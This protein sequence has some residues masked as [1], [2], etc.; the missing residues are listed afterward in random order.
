MS[1]RALTIVLGLGLATAAYVTSGCGASSGTEPT[2]QTAQAA[3]KAPFTVPAHGFVK[4]SLDALGDVPLRPEQ[5]PQIEALAKDAEARHQSSRDAKNALVTAIADQ[6]Q[7]GTLDRA[8]L[9]PKIDALQAA[10]K[11][12]KPLDAA[13]LEKLHA[14]L[15]PEQRAAFV[16]ALQAKWHDH[17]GPEHGGPEHGG[18]PGA[19]HDGPPSSPMGRGMGFGPLAQLGA[20]L[21]LTDD[22]KDKIKQALF[23][24]HDAAGGMHDWRGGMR[25]GHE[26]LEKLTEA[27]KSE[28]FVVAELEPKDS[29][30]KDFMTDHGDKMFKLGQ[31][32]LPILTPEQRTILAGKIRDHAKEE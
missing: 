22:Q 4:V 20:D 2:A 16:A 12:S 30:P 8:A 17:G 9:Q 15:D 3:T 24:Q 29:E 31:A 13:A 5:R 25:E 7:A 11:A 6:V 1:L 21:K 10:M 14:V 19:D 27:F 32:V 23:A 28:H 18:P 26:R